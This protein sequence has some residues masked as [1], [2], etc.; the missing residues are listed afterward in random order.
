MRAARSAGIP[1]WAEVELAY[2]L[3]E[4]RNPI[5]GITGTNGKTTTTL[6]TAAMLERG[7]VPSVGAGNVGTALSTFAGAIEPGRTIV[8]ELSSFQLEGVERFRVRRR[9]A[10]QRDARPPRPPRDVRALRGRQAAGVRAPAR[11]ATPRVLCVD[12]AYVA[13][14]GDADV[15]GDGAAR[16]RLGRRSRAVRGG[17]R[18]LAAARPAQP[19]QCGL[20]DRRRARARRRR[21][22]D[23]R[24]AAR[25]SPRP[26]TGSRTCASCAACATSTTPRRR[27]SRRRCRRSRRSTR[28]CTS[29]SAARS[30][31][32]TSRRS[33]RRSHAPRVP[34]T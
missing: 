24:R 4:E 21:G 26:R 15:P 28:R 14:L 12:D 22:R 25:R 31:A 6:L 23:G 19:R 10:A 20:R 32:P 7:G 18:R 3:L 9:R 11:R 34:C 1:V 17:L 33:R 30:R 29:S 16:A 13:A 5:V 8:C 27:T 2:R